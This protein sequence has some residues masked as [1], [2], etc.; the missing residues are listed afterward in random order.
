MLMFIGV[1]ALMFV[2]VWARCV[3]IRLFHHVNA[4]RKDLLHQE[5]QPP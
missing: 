3:V 5:S 2:V 4:F 1:L